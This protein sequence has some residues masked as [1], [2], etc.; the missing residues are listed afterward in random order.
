MLWDAYLENNGK[1]YYQFDQE[2]STQNNNMRSF[3]GEVGFI[4]TKGV[5]V[6]DIFKE[7]FENIEAV[8]WQ[9]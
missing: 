8:P 7:Y 6:R 9:M 1:A 5:R 2:C 3:S 4:N